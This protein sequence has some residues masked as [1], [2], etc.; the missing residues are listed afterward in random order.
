MKECKPTA[1]THV[2]A[3]SLKIIVHR[4]LSDK[5]TVYL[6]ILAKL[7]DRDVLA[8]RGELKEFEIKA[9]QYAQSWCLE[10]YQA[11]S[12]YL[13]ALNPPSINRSEEIIKND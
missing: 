7:P 2:I 9:L 5:D 13:N 8:V 11:I 3:D 6:T 1:I 10:Q 12:N 4:W